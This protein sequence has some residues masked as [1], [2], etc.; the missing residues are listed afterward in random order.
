MWRQKINNIKPY[1][2]G[3]LL[4]LWL[5]VLPLD[6]FIACF[7]TGRRWCTFSYGSK[8]RNLLLWRT[9]FT[10]WLRSLYIDCSKVQKTN[11]QNVLHI[12]QLLTLC[13][14]VPSNIIL[15][16]REKNTNNVT[17]FIT[18][19]WANL[20]NV[21]NNFISFPLLM[22]PSKPSSS[23]LCTNQSSWISQP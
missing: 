23:Q 3:M 9:Q 16:K 6:F 4:S 2:I 14:R 12:D 7:N 21:I 19:Q 10:S 8:A 11:I 1:L 13:V 5:S 18:T 15:I 17:T 20:G 22:S